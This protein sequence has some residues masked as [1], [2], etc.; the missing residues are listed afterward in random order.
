MKIIFKR[1]QFQSLILRRTRFRLWCELELEGDED[2]LIRHY[3]FDHAILTYT[4]I[5]NLLR[6]A[7]IVGAIAI[8]PSF[9]LYGY[10]LGREAGAWLAVLTG[11][12]A[13]WLYYDFWR[14]TIYI[15]DLLHG[16]DF[17]CWTVTALA[18]KEDELKKL[19]GYF[20]NVLETARNWGG[21]DVVEVPL[22]D[23][24]MAR[25]VIVKHYN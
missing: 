24:E 12:G 11:I 17:R 3:R 13:G 25:K 5:E 15:S 9:F 1:T 23:E 20:R 18:W 7:I 16:R 8:V 14:E 22:F 2:K 4:F 21:G 19:V 6:N 10:W